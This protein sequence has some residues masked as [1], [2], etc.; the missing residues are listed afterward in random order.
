M[1]IRPYSR[2]LIDRN[3]RWQRTRGLRWEPFI[4]PSV[5]L[6]VSGVVE[7]ILKSASTYPRTYFYQI[8]S[9]SVSKL[10]YV[11]YLVMGTYVYQF[12]RLRFHWFLNFNT[13]ENALG[14]ADL[15]TLSNHV[16]FRQVSKGSLVTGYTQEVQNLI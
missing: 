2:F 4:I 9:P 12:R 15:H 8:V 11:Y 13:R 6:K 14:F 1:S 7:A 3:S 5:W 10:Y 16:L